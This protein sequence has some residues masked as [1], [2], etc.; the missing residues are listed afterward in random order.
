MTHI[1]QGQKPRPGQYATDPETD[2]LIQEF[3][4]LQMK[5]GVVYRVT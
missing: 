4:K 2:Q 5:R 3:V 1:T